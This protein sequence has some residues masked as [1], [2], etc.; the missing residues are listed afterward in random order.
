M[1][2]T[3]RYSTMIGKAKAPIYGL[4]MLLLSPFF[5]PTRPKRRSRTATLERT[6]MM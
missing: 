5:F 1:C 4:T 2:F 6:N 3:V